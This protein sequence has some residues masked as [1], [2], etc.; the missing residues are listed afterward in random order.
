MSDRC[1]AGFLRL[2]WLWRYCDRPRARDIRRGACAGAAYR[3]ERKGG[4]R[5]GEL[6]CVAGHVRGAWWQRVRRLHRSEPE[7]DAGDCNFSNDASDSTRFAAPRNSS[8][9]F[10]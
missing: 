9:R 3:W 1:S 7:H 2:N 5:M 10:P 4:Q 6:S 8:K